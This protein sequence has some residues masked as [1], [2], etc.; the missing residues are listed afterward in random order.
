VTPEEWGKVNEVVSKAAGM[1]DPDRRRAYLDECC[2][3]GSSIRSEVDALLA[4]RKKAGEILGNH[5]SLVGE[6][7]LDYQLIEKVGE[8]AAGIVYRAED[9]RLG[10]FVVLKVL[11][12]LLTGDPQ[13]EARFREEARC[14]SAL[15]HP[16]VV[17]VYDIQRDRGALFIVMEYVPGKTLDRIIP[18]EGL[19]VETALHYALQIADALAT[20][21]AAGVIHRDLKPSNI[22]VTQDGLIKVADFG[23]AK[24]LSA[25]RGDASDLTRHG[26]ILGTTGYMS[27]EQARG[28]KA[29]ARS[30]MF[31]FGALLYEM[32]TGRP[33][34]KR[35]SSAETI[36]AILKESPPPP[37]QPIPDPLW[38]VIERCLRKDPDERYQSMDL[39][40]ADLRGTRMAA[41]P[42]VP[43][44]SLQRL[45]AR[46]AAVA[47]AGAALIVTAYFMLSTL[48][49][50]VSSD[51]EEGRR[52]PALAAPLAGP[53]D[54]GSLIA[55]QQVN[56]AVERFTRGIA[57]V[58]R[59]DQ[60]PCLKSGSAGCDFEQAA[61]DLGNSVKE[62]SAI[63]QTHP[64]HRASYWQRGL[65]Y[66]K[67]C[68][69]QAAR[70]SQA[71]ETACTHAIEDF[72]EALKPR[73][74]YPG[75]P[76]AIPEESSIL[77]N[78]GLTHAVRARLK[79]LDSASRIAAFTASIADFDRI[80]A[81]ASEFAAFLEKR[82]PD[83]LRHRD[84]AFREREVL[85]RGAGGRLNP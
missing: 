29:D 57:Y 50:K 82:R 54:S 4:A 70:N 41:A 52:P 17:T 59:V 72:A 39:V 15:N 36:A 84:R 33:A 78:R 19:P 16:N 48:S 73:P 28:E 55:A 20:T 24:A 6:T 3:E 35:N 51:A 64:E 43:T 31:S 67:L 62:F 47:A 23:L 85:L 44:H 32:L 22:L 8:G 18:P 34:F 7:L 60:S 14:L 74:A 10:R 68:F 79:H 69:L 38:R 42:K 25:P 76:T 61:T 21:H 13:S 63:L 12:A 81:G 53:P 5:R 11:P 46:A 1:T 9:T 49:P 2:S 66:S 26:T 37:V 65:A 56:A 83:V 80:L 45:K 77:W 40:S 71:A 27:P 58:A 75:L 30:D